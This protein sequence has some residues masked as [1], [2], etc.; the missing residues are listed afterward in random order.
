MQD[1]STAALPRDLQ[2][3][4][5]AWAEVERQTDA[6]L[7]PLDDE[8]FNWSPSRRVWS[9]AQCFDHLN[10]VNGAYLAGLRRAVARGRAQ[11][12]RRRGP[13]R[14]GWIERRFIAFLEPPVRVRL[15]IPRR[16]HPAGRRLKAEVWPEFVRQHGQLRTLVSG[17]CQE[18]DLNRVRVR[19]PFVR[20]VKIRAG[21]L[22]HVIAAHDRRH[23]WQAR[24]LREMPGFPRS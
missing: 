13:I 1:R 18:V 19:N 6:L 21:A 12:Q 3:L 5:D 15:R 10:M 11:G 2:Q 23:L 7:D 16:M 14:P 9:I 8:Q 17:E 4:I 20:V 24:N 22:L